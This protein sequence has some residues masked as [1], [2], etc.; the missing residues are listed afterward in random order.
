MSLRSIYEVLIEIT[1]S[2]ELA[3]QKI[4]CQSIVVEKVDIHQIRLIQFANFLSHQTEKNYLTTSGFILGT[5]F[6]FYYVQYIKYECF[7]FKY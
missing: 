5:I 2:W 1:E 3:S 4:T 6:H 7:G